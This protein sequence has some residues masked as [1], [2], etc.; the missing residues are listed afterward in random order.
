VCDSHIDELTSSAHGTDLLFE[1]LRGG[2]DG[3]LASCVGD[4]RIKA[5]QSALIGFIASSASAGNGESPLEEYFCSRMLKRLLVLGSAS[6]EPEE[7]GGVASTDAEL[8]QYFAAD[9]W[10]KLV[11]G[12]CAALFETHAAKVLA[13]LMFCGH[14]ATV[15][16]LRKELA[17]VLKPKKITAD[18][19]AE[20][21]GLRN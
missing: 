14:D 18:A 17:G 7:A 2:E 3:L 20:S 13:A 11:K 15:K 12:Q 16:E 4:K 8:V 1:V 9:L 21:L 6:R 5:V 10:K 19:W